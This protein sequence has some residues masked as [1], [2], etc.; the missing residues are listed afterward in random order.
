MAKTPNDV[1]KRGSRRSKRPQFGSPVQADAA[2][3]SYPVEEQGEAAPLL[4]SQTPPPAVP[5][6]DAPLSPSQISPQKTVTEILKERREETAAE[7]VAGRIFLAPL[8]GAGGELASEIGGTLNSLN[9]IR[10]DKGL[11]IAVAT[12]IVAFPISL[13]AG[14]IKAVYGLFNGWIN[15]TAGIE[16]R[17]KEVMKAPATIGIGGAV[18]AGGA[19][20]IGAPIAGVT[21]YLG[22]I[23]NGPRA[24]YNRGISLIKEGGFFNTLRGALTIFPG[25]ALSFAWN[26][27]AKGIYNIGR[28]IVISLSSPFRERKGDLK[29]KDRSQ[30]ID[31]LFGSEDLDFSVATENERKASATN[32]NNRASIASQSF[33]VKAMDAE[34][35]AP[36]AAAPTSSAAASP[37]TTPPTATSGGMDLSGITT[38]YQAGS[39]GGEA[40]AAAHK[41]AVTAAPMMMSPSS[42]PPKAAVSSFI[43]TQVQIKTSEFIDDKTRARWSED[44]IS[45]SNVSG[46]GGHQGIRVEGSNLIKLEEA[47]ISLTTKSSDSSNI[48]WTFPGNDPY[49]TK[50]K[51][52]EMIN[53]VADRA[54][55][56]NKKKLDKVTIG[57]TEYSVKYS[58]V[59]IGGYGVSAQ[60]EKSPTLTS[61]ART[62]PNPRGGSSSE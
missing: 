30:L 44:R 35:P 6:E 37:I 34:N 32:Q 49:F 52:Q 46:A 22:G 57:D 10:K 31:T 42:T 28:G 21:Q 13:I 54:N 17:A 62:R 56:T 1:P 26:A 18:L 16:K 41:T 27:T 61:T 12:G 8:L 3:P 53:V 38:A 59:G 7:S 24:A 43:N 5:A 51:I 40:V 11:G 45:A 55:S 2:A 4:P 9:D 29:P 60:L 25:A 48:A 36:A 15:G 19:A 23:W 14:P 58:K 39:A 50:E 47:L 20:L 33:I